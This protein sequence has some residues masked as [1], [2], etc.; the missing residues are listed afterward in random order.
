[1]TYAVPRR[2]AQ[3]NALSPTELLGGLDSDRQLGATGPSMSGRTGYQRYPV[4]IGQGRTVEGLR[5][6]YGAAGRCRPQITMAYQPSPGCG[7]QLEY[8][9]PPPVLIRVK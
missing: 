3:P 8:V 2:A 6:R 5:F 1:M 7:A 9:M 4:F